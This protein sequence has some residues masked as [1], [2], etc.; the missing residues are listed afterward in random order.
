MVNPTDGAAT[1]S[2]CSLSVRGLS[3]QSYQVRSVV[4]KGEL[5]VQVDNLGYRRFV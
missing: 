5:C 1:P 3:L 2:S 4:D